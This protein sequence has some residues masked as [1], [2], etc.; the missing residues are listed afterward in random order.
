MSADVAPIMHSVPMNVCN[1]VVASGQGGFQI[2]TSCGNSQ[3]ATSRGQ[4]LSVHVASSGSVKNFDVLALGG[5]IKS[6]DARAG[7]RRS[8]IAARGEHNARGSIVGPLDV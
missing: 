4:P 3:D 2:W 7:F 6:F 1:R 8:G 5:A